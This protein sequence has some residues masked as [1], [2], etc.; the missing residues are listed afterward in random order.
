MILEPHVA[1]TLALQVP[2][3]D[4]KLNHCGL[5]VGF[6]SM[7]GVRI[8]GSE[9]RAE[10][11]GSEVGATDLGVELGAKICGSEVSATSTPPRMP[12]CAW[13]DTLEL[14]SMAP[15]CVTSES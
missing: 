10:I 15:R 3:F 4:I 1:F 11:H 9:L 6:E 8:H 7:L 2:S 14:R 5:A 13:P 12:C